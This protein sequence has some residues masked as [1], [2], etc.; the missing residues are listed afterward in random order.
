MVDGLLVPNNVLNEL[1]DPMLIESMIELKKHLGH[2]SGE[3]GWI[4]DFSLKYDTDRFPSDVSIE[5]E[6]VP[7]KIKSVASILS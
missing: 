6:G 5:L 3:L 1:I 2:R 7:Q 4:E